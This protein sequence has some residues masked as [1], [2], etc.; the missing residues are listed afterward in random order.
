V[1][2]GYGNPIE[3][4][5][6]GLDLDCG[7]PGTP[8]AHVCFDPCQNYTLLDEPFRSTEN[9]AGSQGCDKNMSGWY[10]F[11]GEGGVRMSE[12]C[13][14]VHRCQ[15]DAPMW[16]NGTHPALG[17]GITNHTA[18]AHWSGNCCFW[19]TEVL[20]KACPG[21]YHV[22]RLEGTPWCNLRYCTDPSHHHHHHHH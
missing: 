6:Y 17:D 4:S 9:S 12:T 5:S 18:C 21:G 11:V 1:Q 13:V 14:Q 20:V 22:Y 2:R 8:E 10:R 15:T 19:K 7:A 16:L 3:A